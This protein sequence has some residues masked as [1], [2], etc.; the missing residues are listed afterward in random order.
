[1]N[2]S[3]ELPRDVSLNSLTVYM[4]MNVCVSYTKHQTHS[5]CISSDVLVLFIFYISLKCLFSP[6]VR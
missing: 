5:L 2:H 3:E 6:S 1:M 4:C